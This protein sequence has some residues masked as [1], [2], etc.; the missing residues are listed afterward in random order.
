MWTV[1]L[2]MVS[3][4]AWYWSVHGGPDGVDVL[5]AHADTLPKALAVAAVGVLAC[6]LAAWIV[7]GWAKVEL[8]AAQALL[9]PSERARLER[10]VGEL[11]ETRAGAVEAQASEL[12]RMERNLHDGAQARLVALAMDLG[13]AEEKLASDDTEQA[14]RLVAGARA[15]AKQAL[16]ELRDLVRGMQPHIR[17]DRGLEAAIPAL[18]GSARLSAGVRVEVPRRLA[19]MAEGRSNASIAVL[20]VT[21]GAVEKHITSIFSKL[22]LPPSDTHHRRVLAVLAYLRG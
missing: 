3:L 10:R 15:Q 7:R 18:A 11:T 20:V 5:V 12:E 9:G 4:P 2:G 6:V 1:A 21:E 8:M 14:R 17:R 16:T 13:M 19:L 22:S